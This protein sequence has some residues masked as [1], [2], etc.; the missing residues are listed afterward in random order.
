VVGVRFGHDWG[1]LGLPYDEHIYTEADVWATP[2]PRLTG[3]QPDPPPAVESDPI[4]WG[5]DMFRHHVVV[6]RIPG[7]LI[8]GRWVARCLEEKCG[9]GTGPLSRDEAIRRANRHGYADVTS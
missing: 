1:G 4:E 8:G 9:M 2:F 5:S 7:A 3:E 6:H